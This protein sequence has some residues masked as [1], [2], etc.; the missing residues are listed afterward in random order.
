MPQLKH[1]FCTIEACG[2]KHKARGYCNV[3]Y[4]QY[5]RGGPITPDIKTRDRNTP[6]QCVEHNCSSPVKSKGYCQMHYVR[7]VR[8]GST[9]CPERTKP[10]KTCSVAGCD[11]VLY[12]SG[13]CG[14][15]SQ[16]ERKLR[17]YGLTPIQYDEM[18][19]AQGGVCYI[20][21][22]DNKQLVTRSGEYRDLPVDHC[23][24]TGKVRGILCSDC[25]RGLG[26][27]K[28]DTGRLKAAIDY[29]DRAGF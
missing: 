14:K 13:M 20:C 8:Y 26:S 12:Y 25:N 15:H 2:R 28:D 5:K 21:K 11:R 4:A 16:I 7:I 9:D 1:Q 29:L 18:L 24:K 6:P 22:T 17:R 10:E 27:F 23:H 3:H 19:S